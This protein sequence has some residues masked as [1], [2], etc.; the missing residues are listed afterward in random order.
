MLTDSKHI[1]YLFIYKMTV[2][3]LTFLTF[4]ITIVHN[5]KKKLIKYGRK[6]IYFLFRF[7]LDCDEESQHLR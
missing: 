3:T 1:N 7:N 4:K 6:T 2:K 5:I